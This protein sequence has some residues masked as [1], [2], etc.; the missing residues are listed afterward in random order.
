MST[1]T[2]PLPPADACALIETA[3]RALGGDAGELARAAGLSQSG[4]SNIKAGRAPLPEAAEIRLT[5]IADGL[6]PETAETDRAPAGDERAQRLAEAERFLT[7]LDDEA[8]SWCFQTFDDSGQRAELARTLHGEL[9]ELFDTLDELNR[10]GAGVF[11]TINEVR[12][13]APRTAAN[14]AR[15]RAVF[16]DHDPPKTKAAPGVYP[17]APVLEVE[18][19]AG[20]T[21]CY[22]T[23]DGLA[24]EDFEPQQRG[25]AAR[26]GSDPAVIDLPRVMRLPG[27]RHTKD[28]SRPHWVRTITA[29]P[30]L[31]YRP[32]DLA[33]AFPPVAKVNG[34]GGERPDP[35]ADPIARALDA[36]GLVLREKPGGGLF[37]TCPWEDEHTTPNTPT[38]TV[39][40][41]PHTGGYA[42][43]AFKCQHGHCTDRT[44]ADLRAWL[45]LTP[46]PSAEHGAQVAAAII[47]ASQAAAPWPEPEPL[48]DVLPPVDAFDP[49]MLPAALRPWIIDIAER[50]QCPPDFPA[51]AAVV[52]LAAVVGRQVAIRPKRHDDWT[53]VPNLWG[54][55]IGRPSL[56]KSPALAEPMRLVDALEAKAADF[57]REALREH[58]AQARVDAIGAKLADADI[59]KALKDG[60]RGKALDLALDASTDDEPPRRRRYRTSDATIEKL[61]ELLKDNPRGLLLFRDELV[62]FLRSL[63]REGREGSRA[64][65]LECWNGN[66]GFVFLCL[67]VRY[68]LSAGRKQALGFFS[69]SAQFILPG[70]RG[71]HVASG[72]VGKLN[73]RMHDGQ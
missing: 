40:F 71:V 7:A 55:I 4:L 45:G 37:I 9:G 19:S 41:P 34:T 52:C 20:R 31:P 64:F 35:G 30:R 42:G 27:F 29:D 5:R 6:P 68:R 38:S 2:E 13:G 72:N 33:R 44:A 73:V 1:P 21:H 36:R 49:A 8:E 28:P 10:R 39:Y 23:V 53:V 32:E 14:V 61:G 66:G 54:G 62:G 43:A 57:H 11:V 12:H 25:I 67:V 63:D 24:L 56:L 48:P 65:Y 69:Q 60:D 70:G 59:Q 46:E 22:W 3:H 17:L 58:G 16:A 51:A 26:L 18:S 50:M 47:G 15:V